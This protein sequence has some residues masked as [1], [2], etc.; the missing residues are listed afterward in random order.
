MFAQPSVRLVVAGLALVSAS[1]LVEGR[2]A[3]QSIYVSVTGKNGVPVTGLTAADFSLEVNGHAAAFVAA[4][5]AGDPVQAAVVFNFYPPAGI[6]EFA[7]ALVEA[8]RASVVAVTRLEST[9]DA[10]TASVVAL[11]P[12]SSDVQNLAAQLTHQ[13]AVAATMHPGGWGSAPLA[14][15]RDAQLAL[16][17]AHATRPVIVEFFDED[18]EAPGSGLGAA[19][20]DSLAS[21]TVAMQAFNDAMRGTDAS[22]WTIVKPSAIYRGPA[23]T[24]ESTERPE[25]FEQALS[26]SLGRV[27]L[28]RRRGAA[29]GR[30]DRGAT[31][32]FPKSRDLDYRRISAHVRGAGRREAARQGD[33]RRR[34]CQRAR[35]IAAAAVA[36]IARRAG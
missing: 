1:A 10:Y 35:E 4:G 16:R 9:R 7:E 18:I 15:L 21:A 5:A 6:A 11:P 12:F 33:A 14:R 19:D 20:D 23:G 17:S 13:E 32:E 36:V 25:R 30:I 24:S 28:E 2:A 3:D 31:R 8:D 22:I 34:A 29:L 26:F 27:E